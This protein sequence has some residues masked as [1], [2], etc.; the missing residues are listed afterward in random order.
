MSTSLRVR[1][2]A[3]A[4]RDLEE[5]NAYIA[6]DN[7]GAAGKLLG[8]IEHGV[9]LL[10]LFPNKA[11]RS[12]KNGVRAL[13]LSRYPYIIFYRVVGRELVVTRVLHGARRH[14]GFREEAAVFASL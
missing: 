14:L 12:S 2:T 8:A 1:Y 5:I 3:K 13:V 7:P 11:R 10:T 6:L 9:G 4:F